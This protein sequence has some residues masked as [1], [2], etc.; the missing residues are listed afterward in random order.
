MGCVE[1][2]YL[3]GTPDLLV[4]FSRLILLGFS[5]GEAAYAAQGSLSWQT[6]VVGDPLYRPFARQPPQMH[7]DLTA[8]KSKLAEW[9]ILRAINQNMA[10]GDSPAR[11]IEFLQQIADT[12]ES[13]LLLEKLGDLFTQAGQPQEAGESY[14]R[15]LKQGPSPQQQIRLMFGLAKAFE[16]LNRTEEAY[17]TYRRFVKAFP[18]FPGLDTL[19]PKL[20]S[21]AGQLGKQN[22]KEQYLQEIERLS[23]A[24]K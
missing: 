22:D 10:L 17:E 5:F 21:F 14:E 13:A 23:S 18:D 19:Y 20:A 9:S 2:P 12:S 6:T 24:R 15:S 4:F 16:A 7:A 11:Y 1:E 8:R 3:E